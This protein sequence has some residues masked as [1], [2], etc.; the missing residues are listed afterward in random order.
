MKELCITK[1]IRDLA[2]S[3]ALL[4]DYIQRNF[5]RRI[6]RKVQSRNKFKAKST[7]STYRVK[8]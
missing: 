7:G 3:K 6:Y 8:T 5:T 2:P 1:W 4:Y